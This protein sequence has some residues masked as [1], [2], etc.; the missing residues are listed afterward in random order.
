MA[1]IH[2]R[3]R[4]GKRVS[5]RRLCVSRSADA[6]DLLGVLLVALIGLSTEAA[7]LALWC[8]PAAAK[9]DDATF[10]G[11]RKCAKVWPIHDLVTKPLSPPCEEQAVT[12]Q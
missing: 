12:C 10:K 1:E 11:R 5:R 3:G 7:L 4:G 2:P 8:S 9:G 6:A